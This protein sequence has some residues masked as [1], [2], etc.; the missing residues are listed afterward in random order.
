MRPIDLIVV[1]CSATPPTMDIG[2]KEIRT[3]HLKKN[4]DDIGYHFVIRRDG[5]IEKGRDIA[6]QGAHAYPYNKHSIGICL[7][8]GVD[9]AKLAEDNFSVE[10][11]E[12]LKWLVRGLT[13]EYAGA[14]VCG[15]RDL[16]DVHKGCPS[17]DVAEYLRVLQN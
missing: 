3:W 7:V 12:M 10:Q 1:H 9:N 11:Y 14:R 2:V 17:F 13:S 15:H 8:G 16:P 4:W 6:T 5:S